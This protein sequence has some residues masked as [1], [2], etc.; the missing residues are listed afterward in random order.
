MANMTGNGT[1]NATFSSFRRFAAKDL[2]KDLSKDLY[3]GPIQRPKDYIQRTEDIMSGNSVEFTAGFFGMK[4]IQAIIAFRAYES[5][6]R[7][8][9]GQ[10]KAAL[11]KMVFERY[12]GIQGDEDSIGLAEK[13]F[14]GIEM[15]EGIYEDVIDPVS[16]K[17]ERVLK[18]V[19]HCFEKK[20]VVDSDHRLQGIN[21]T[22]LTANKKHDLSL[23]S[24]RVIWDMAKKVEEN[25]RKAMS[26][27]MK[28][29]KYKDGTVSSGEQ[30]ED[31]LKFCRY[32]MMNL[33]GEQANSSRSSA[34]AAEEDD[35]LPTAASTN[36]LNETTEGDGLETDP[37]L[38][39]TA[40]EDEELAKIKEWNNPWFFK[41]FMAWAL[42]GHIP[43]PG[44]DPA[45]KSKLFMTGDSSTKRDKSNGRKA[46]RK[47][48]AKSEEKTRSNSSVAEGRGVSRKDERFGEYLSHNKEF[49]SNINYLAE[50]QWE[51]GQK[52]RLF[53]SISKRIDTATRDMD[54]LSGIVF[55][56]PE[57]WDDLES[58][59]EWPPLKQYLEASEKK[60]RL[61][62]RLAELEESIE[63]EMEQ[64]NVVSGK[65]RSHSEIG[66]S[67]P[68]QILAQ[69]EEK[70]EEEYEQDNSQEDGE[71][72]DNE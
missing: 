2:S 38:I 36:N 11:Q 63:R 61:E 37:D 24:G 25:G 41:G 21:M 7:E 20:I 62:E 70:D 42:W 43:M 10:K 66:S 67:V 52:A 57:V 46:T 3:R 14:R 35:T 39:E 18:P 51:D 40:Q 23:I 71:S 50:R 56:R 17:S 15:F 13:F 6:C 48:Q 45:Y 9:T 47:S 19:L 29:S 27:V 16:Q 22:S 68:S 1:D 65:K 26:I 72:D 30:W 49:Q 31:Y 64:A 32:K 8:G 54:R 44:M 12:H 28:S 55:S 59:K 69:E 4:E 53:D 60:E 58:H 5:V 34:A 33:I